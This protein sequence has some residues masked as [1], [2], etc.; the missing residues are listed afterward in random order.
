MDALNALDVTDADDGSRLKIRAK[1][2][3]GRNKVVEVRG[4][5]LLVAV[6]DP[7]EKGKANEAIRKTLAKGLGVS[8]SSVTIV[9][10]ETHRDKRIHV[11]GLSAADVRERLHTLN[12][13][14]S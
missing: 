4:D 13:L 14:A 6:T 10:G 8:K 9:S 12:G 5:A 7:P 11:A 3:A 1:P 2:R